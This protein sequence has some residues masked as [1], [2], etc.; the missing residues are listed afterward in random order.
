V[1]GP[2]VVGVEASQRSRDAV[3]LARRLAALIEAELVLVNAYPNEPRGGELQ[4]PEYERLV[5]GES[6]ELLAAYLRELD[7]ER[8]RTRSFASFSPARVL[9]ETAEEERAALVVLGATHRGA[10][11]RLA[12]GSVADR[13]LTGAPCPVAV[14][15]KDYEHTVGDAGFG[16]VGVAFTATDAGRS[17]LRAAAELARR[18]AAPLQVL[19]VADPR[20]VRS[21]VAAGRAGRVELEGAL[22]EVV[23]R[24]AGEAVASLADGVDARAVV[25]EGDPVRELVA[26][27]RSLDLLICGSR[28]YGPATT[29]LV[30][31]VSKELMREGSCPVVV[32][33]RETDRPLSSSPPPDAP[34]SR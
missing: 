30:G 19:A 31:G 33:P 3:V 34:R 18:A 16:R 29:V 1:H 22:R 20:I 5:H 11:G 21:D 9:H 10:P 6:D 17:A 12:I 32:V 28:S 27:T 2:V 4:R 7:G 23:E 8:V 15:P 13:L 26:A 25:L 14:A 24:A